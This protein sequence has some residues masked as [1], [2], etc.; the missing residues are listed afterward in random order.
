MTQPTHFVLAGHL[1]W[2][3]LTS[4]GVS[5]KNLASFE[6][7]W[8][9]EEFSQ[10]NDSKI[11]LSRLI[12][13]AAFDTVGGDVDYETY[14]ISY[15][16]VL[17]IVEAC[18]FAPN[19]LNQLDFEWNLGMGDDTAKFNAVIYPRPDFEKIEGITLRKTHDSRL[20][21]ERSML[22]FRVAALMMRANRGS[23]LTDDDMTGISEIEKT[24]ED[25]HVDEL[26]VLYANLKASQ[27]ARSC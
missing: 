16:D 17:K 6:F 12:M 10:S 7:H 8:D 22:V 24:I 2:E 19:Q 14:L 21:Q 4:A 9:A 11:T 3:L 23:D 15:A 26:R 1:I 25:K 5:T 27:D 20:E 13:P 18:G